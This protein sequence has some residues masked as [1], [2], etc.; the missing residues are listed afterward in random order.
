MPAPRY[1]ERSAVTTAPIPTPP[2]GTTSVSGSLFAAACPARTAPKSARHS[3]GS[4]L[5]V[6]R[7]MPQLLIP[8]ATYLRWIVVGFVVLSVHPA[9]QVHAQE[10]VKLQRLKTPPPPWPSGDERGMANQVG[11]A[12]WARCAYH[13]S[14]PGAKVYEV[15]QPRSN[16]MPLSPFAGPYAVKPKSTAGIPGSAHAFNSETMNEGAE[17]GQQGTQIDAIGHFGVRSEPWDGKA[18]FDEAK[19]TYYGRHSQQEVKPAGGTPLLK[20]RMGKAP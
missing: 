9:M 13:L 2:V 19:I 20:P 17:Y 15:S 8:M 6:P 4:R 1:G 5:S 16:T 14:L 7:T 18:V 12:T 11:P 10:P 3:L